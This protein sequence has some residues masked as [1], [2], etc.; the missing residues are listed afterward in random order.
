MS[1]QKKTHSSFR[2][3]GEKI[4][5]AFLERCGHVL[6]DHNYHAGF[7]EID[8]I[9]LDENFTIHFS[10]VKNWQSANILQH[11]L[12]AFNKKRIGKLRDAAQKFIIDSNE[13]SIMQERVAA[14][15]CAQLLHQLPLSF[16]LLWVRSSTH[17]EYQPQIF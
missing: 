4:A 8:L 14:T 3:E 6:L 9:T 11:P 12:E 17:I 5:L 1:V 13:N 2:H 7:C 16:D 10:E 15:A